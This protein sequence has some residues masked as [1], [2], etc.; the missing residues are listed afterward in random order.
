ML[1]TNHAK[2]LLVAA[3]LLVPLAGCSEP[4]ES[5]E[6]AAEPGETEMAAGELPAAEHE[7]T[8]VMVEGYPVEVVTHAS[9]EVYAWVRAEEVPVPERTVLT[10]EVPTEQR[11]TGRPVRMRWSEA[12]DRWE[13]R[14]RRLTIVPGPLVVV[15]EVDGAPRT[16]HVDIIVV[17]PAIAVTIIETEHHGHGHKHKHRHG[18]GHGRGRGRGHGGVEVRFH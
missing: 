6:V 16:G 13:G 10:I 11:A 14:V 4:D 15:L 5:F 17:A 2:I 3:S 18:H 9:G 12:H 7:G 8:M 1:H